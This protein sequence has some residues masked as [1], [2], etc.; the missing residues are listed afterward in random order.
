[1]AAGMTYFP[2]ATQT[3]VSTAATVT[4]SSIPATY[5]DLILII[6]GKYAASDDS[7]PSI[8]FNGDTSTNYSVTALNGDGTNTSS[9]REASQTQ[10]PVG[11]MSGEQST[12]IVNI[13]NYTNTTTY[14]TVISRGNASTRVRTY[15]GLWRKTP[16]AI[17]QIDILRATTNNFAIG[18]TFT[19]YGISA[20]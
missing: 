13:M 20:A 12:T 11:S 5:T 17:N 6:N 1:M 14:K 16:E 2:I 3:L 18:S 4:F 10:V 19:L 9:F 7:S 8:Q 15:V